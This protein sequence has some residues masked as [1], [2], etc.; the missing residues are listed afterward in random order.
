MPLIH[1]IAKFSIVVTVRRNPEVSVWV[2]IHC[3]INFGCFN[4]IFDCLSFWLTKG[5]LPSINF[6]TRITLRTYFINSKLKIVVSIQIYTWIA[7][8][9]FFLTRYWFVKIFSDIF[10][11]WPIITTPVF[12]YVYIT[13]FIYIRNKNKIKL[14]YYII[15]MIC[16][17]V[18]QLF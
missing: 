9:T 14:W 12:T 10:F 15:V 2:K 16:N 7:L 6:I 3:S 5:K 4:K 1:F 17:D 11:L 18:S 8:W 13:I